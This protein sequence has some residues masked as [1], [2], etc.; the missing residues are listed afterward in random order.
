MNEYS[1]RARPYFE[2]LQKL[3]PV[4]REH[5]DPPL[6]ARQVQ[7]LASGAARADA[8]HLDAPP[9]QY[10]RARYMADAHRLPTLLMRITLATQCRALPSPGYAEVMLSPAGNSAE[11]RLYSRVR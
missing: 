10:Q 11:V 1:E 8:A 9:A 5:A 7:F 3:A 2:K 4:I 6:P